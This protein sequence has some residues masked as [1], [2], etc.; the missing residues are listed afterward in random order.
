MKR[1]KTGAKACDRVADWL[2][3]TESEYK[4]QTLDSV[5]K[6]NK[7]IKREHGPS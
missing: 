7:D 2:S 6:Q 3:G 5:K 1:T 4:I